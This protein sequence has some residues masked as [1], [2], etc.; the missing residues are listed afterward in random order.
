MHAFRALSQCSVCHTSVLKVLVAPGLSLGRSTTLT[1]FLES[2]LEPGLGSVWTPSLTLL[3]AGVPGLRRGSV[4]MS[5]K[6]V[7]VPEAKGNHGSIS[8]W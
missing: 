7:T 2:F 6:V 5:P 1:L 8:R 3:E 4:Q